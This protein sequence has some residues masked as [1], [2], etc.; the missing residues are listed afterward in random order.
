M[1]NISYK[2]VLFVLAFILVTFVG[3]CFSTRGVISTGVVI[4]ASKVVRQKPLGIGGVVIE[5]HKPHFATNA[6]GIDFQRDLKDANIKLVRN[7]TYP[8]NRKPQHKLDYFDRNVKAIIKAGGT[9]LFIQYIKPDLPYFKTDG[10]LRGTIASNVV[11]LVKHYMAPPYNIT[12]QY[13]QIGN[14]P[15]LT[16][17]YKV[18]SA[19]EYANYFNAVHD[20]L[21][22]AG[23]REN[24]ILI[25]PGISYGYH[26]PWWEPINNYRS[27]IMDYFLANCN[28]AV[29]I[30]NF[31]SYANEKGPKFGYELLNMPR[32][33]DNKANANRAIN[34]DDTRDNSNT[35]NRGLAALIKAM[36]QYTF[37]RAN[38]GVGLTEHNTGG[39]SQ[40]TIYQ[41]LW[42]LSVTH[43]YLYNPL[44]LL[45]SAFIFD[46]SGGPFAH[47]TD[48]KQKNYAYWALWINGNLRGSQV[49]K[50]KNTG[51][52]NEYGRPYLLVTATKNESSIF[53]EVINRSLKSIKESVQIKGTSIVDDSKIFT[54]AENIFPNQAKT[55]KLGTEFEYLFPPFS[56]TIFKI[57]VA[58]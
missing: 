41:G 20:A 48:D 50:Q 17:D 31:N 45:T 2:L 52:L 5:A 36:N 8:D 57:P 13:W 37:S 15:D 29:D 42:N 54:M 18:S 58:K 6:N 53:V 34:V 19:A 22:Q 47:Y 10:N 7:V 4:D 33:L 32:H 28:H 46:Y 30:V 11:Y 1:K 51:H 12:K 24:V 56:V 40:D 23:L 25:G 14:E 9:P 38:V 49:L 43:Y 3:V 27:Q 35:S 16:V 44:A 21:V 39:E 55:A 26:E